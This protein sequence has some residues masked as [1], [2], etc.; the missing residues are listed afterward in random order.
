MTIDNALLKL[1]LRLSEFPPPI[2][3]YNK[4]HSGSRL[5]AE[6]LMAQ[7]VFLGAEIN[8]SR[9]SLPVLQVVEDVVTQ[10]YP[11]YDRLWRSTDGNQARLAVETGAA[12]NRHLAGYDSRQGQR[13][14]W[15]LCETPYAL[16]FFD[17][18]FPAATVVHL[19]RDGRDVAWSDH[20]APELPFWRKIYFNTDRIQ[21]W[22]RRSLANAAYERRPYLYNAIHWAN[23]VTVGRAYGTMLRERYW[24]IR[25]EDLCHDFS[26]SVSRLMANLGMDAVEGKID[27][28]AP[29]VYSRSVGK[30]RSRPIRAQRAVVELIGPVLASFDYGSSPGDHAQDRVPSR[31]CRLWQ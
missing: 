7:G 9:D 30:H 27:R 24:E 13:W 2:I 14:G 21:H 12:F 18:L 17:F 28:M 4:S 6:S 26:G 20:V 5:L 31:W 15:K 19:I 1:R 23:S 8:E 16:P 22:Q 3:L 11:D 29:L 25:Y 10:Y